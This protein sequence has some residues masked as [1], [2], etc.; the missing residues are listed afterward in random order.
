MSACGRGLDMSPLPSSSVPLRLPVS[1]P[2]SIRDPPEFHLPS[3]GALRVRGHHHHHRF[4]PVL[5]VLRCHPP[6][7]L[8]ESR[9]LPAPGCHSYLTYAHSFQANPN[10]SYFDFRAGKAVT[11]PYHTYPTMLPSTK[12]DQDSASQSVTHEV[13]CVAP[14]TTRSAVVC[15]LVRDGPSPQSLANDFSHLTNYYC[16]MYSTATNNPWSSS[17]HPSS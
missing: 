14:S 6:C 17:P 8:H 15:P 16:S 2:I 9:P 5:D 7:V 13:R 4:P 3:P 1:R 10:P 11:L 12:L